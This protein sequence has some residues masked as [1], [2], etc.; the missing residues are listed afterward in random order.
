[1]YYKRTTNFIDVLQDEY[2]LKEWDRRMVATGMAENPELVMSALTV[3]PDRDVG[4]TPEDKK[5]LQEIADKAKEF[6]KGSAA[7][8]IG[9]SLHTFT[10]WM[11]EGRE[12]GYVPEPYPADL[13]A[14]ELATKDIRWTNIES[15]R[16]HDDWKV[17]GT[18]DRIGYYR[19]RLTIFDIKTGSLFL[20]FGAPMQLAMYAHSTPYD[21][22]T[23]TRTS[24]VDELRLDVGY[25]IHLP[26]GSGHCELKPVNLV[27]GWEGCL[28]AKAVW[29]FR[30]RP[31]SDFYL[32]RDAYA[33]LYEMALRAGS[34]KECKVLWANGKDMG[35]LDH[36]MRTALTNRAKELAS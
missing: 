14:Y 4:Q 9:T 31:E 3:K 2:K 21:I 7:A 27:S 6:A 19:G 13:A 36:A 5:A 1:V 17:G 25:V 8:A 32:D 26:A 35:L 10:Q 24:D 33:Q 28:E 12:L 30:N 11:D 15:F 22:A 18:T 20:K 16:V 29:D 23:D 34:V